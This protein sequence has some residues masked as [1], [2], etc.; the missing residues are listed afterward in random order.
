MEKIILDNIDDGIYISDLNT[1]RLLYINRAL[2][3]RRGLA[4]IVCDALGNTEDAPAVH[5]ITPPSTPTTPPA[6]NVHASTT[7]SHTTNANAT[8]TSTPTPATDSAPASTY[9]PASGAA[10]QCWQVLYPGL[11]APCADCPRAELLANRDSMLATDGEQAQWESFDS[12]SNRYYKNMSRIVTLPDGRQAQLVHSSE[13]TE[14]RE[15]LVRVENAKNDYMSR[16]SH[17]ILT[18]MNA[19]VGMSKIAGATSDMAKIKN[20]LLKIDE[21]SKQLLGIISSIVDISRLEADRLQ[22]A[23]SNV[24]LEQMLIEVCAETMARANEK[25]QD[26]QVVIDRDVP[27]VFRTDGQRLA[28]VILHL[29]L[30]AVKFTPAGGSIHLR[31][32]LDKCD[33]RRVGIVFTVSDDG[34][35][36]SPKDME[37][38][39]DAFEQ[40]DGTRTRAHGGIGLGLAVAR[41]LVRLLGG[42]I[43]VVSEPNKGSVFT[44]NI[45]AETAGDK[46]ARSTINK[47]ADMELSILYAD[48]NEEARDY[49]GMLMREYGIPYMCVESGFAALDSIERAKADNNPFSIIFVDM[50]MQH[51]NGVE[52][53]RQVHSKFGDEP[54]AVLMAGVEWDIIEQV[55]EEAGIRYFLP[56]PLFPSKI[57]D[58]INQIIGPQNTCHIA[59]DA[60]TDAAPNAAP[61]VAPDAAINAAPNATSNAAPNT[62]LDDASAIAD[63]AADVA[64]NAHA[65][66]GASSVNAAGDTAAGTSSY[67]A[68]YNLADA[69]HNAPAPDFSKKRILLVDDVA[70][71]R[72]IIAVYLA[73]TGVALDYAR[74]G[75]EA[76]AMYCENP[77]EYDMILMDLHMPD[78]DGCEATI[79]IR[80]FENAGGG[81]VPILALTAEIFEKDVARCRLAGMNGYLQKPVSQWRLLDKLSEIFSHGRHA[82][83]WA[84]S[85]AGYFVGRMYNSGA[86]A[87]ASPVDSTAAKIE[88][89]AVASGAGVYNAGAIGA[90]AVASPT[91]V[92]LAST[93]PA[94]TGFASAGP[95]TAGLSAASP[96]AAGHAE[97]PGDA[98]RGTADN[99]SNA[100]GAI[101]YSQY[102]AFLPVFDVSAALKKLKNI[103]KLYIAMLLM[104]KKNP[105]FKELS[106]ALEKSDFI[107]IGSTA[108]SLATVAQ[109]LYLNELLTILRQIE[110][111]ALHK[112]MRP[113]LADM[114]GAA[115]ERVFAKLD[116]LI[117]ALNMEADR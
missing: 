102:D 17:E 73:P 9:A 116:D 65:A 62:A 3:E 68:V 93:S 28:Q 4:G 103:R 30:N 52:T 98:P 31:A 39:F 10:A 83:G 84:Y 34:V 41:R 87:A 78:M 35:G 109:N 95:T 86:S 90:A 27:P 71:N 56:K 100:A 108:R 11:D 47:P 104:L 61:N 53:I 99:H 82:S 2:S 49:F 5:V 96:T 16:M 23:Y 7:A 111:M 94:S 13:I 112:I 72:D 40:V 25:G 77:S 29:L 59:P 18:P 63:A 26:F 110:T 117:S 113:G 55:A 76:I 74:G 50:R 88:G 105:L 24:R 48:G 79:N 37:H 58:T 42:D 38:L 33:E 36:I 22:L 19:I 20:C 45:I 60:V 15:R 6:A 97:K 54:V 89:A 81:G 67:A 75:M 70:V 101:D 64:S 46:T 80:T 66:G 21:A 32:K 51:L 69:G 85:G 107:S 12:A 114:Y 44:L 14:V 106:A 8:A 92:S 91:S 57:I 43:T 1:Y 115:S